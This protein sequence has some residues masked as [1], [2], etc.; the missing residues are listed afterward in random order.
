MSSYLIDAFC[1]NEYAPCISHVRYLCLIR[2]ILRMGCNNGRFVMEWQKV[3][4]GK[5]LIKNKNP[6]WG[7]LCKGRRGRKGGGGGGRTVSSS[8]AREVFASHF[9]GE[10]GEEGPV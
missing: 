4:E 2:L 3:G 5:F 10:D 1:G 8:A 9:I 7:H 6:K